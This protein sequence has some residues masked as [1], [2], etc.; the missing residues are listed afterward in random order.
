MR[1]VVVS[2]SAAN[3]LGGAELSLLTLL[4]YWTRQDPTVEPLVIG[5]M[6]SAA[7]TREV[8][9]RGWRSFD[10]PMTGWAVWEADGGRAQ[11]RL[12]EV[13]NAAAAKH[14]VEVLKVEQPDLVISNTLV[15][16]WGAI[17][18]AHVGVP[19]V[20]FVREFG[21]S[22]QGFLFPGGRE[23]ALSDIGAL[24]HTIV[25]NSRV[26]ADALRPH[27]P[28][29]DIAV[30]Y[31]PVD[32]E[33]VRT[34]ALE[35]AEQ[36]FGAGSALRVSVLGRVTGSKGQWRLIEA[37]GRLGPADIQVRFVG[38]ILD[39]G[40]DRQL[41]RRARALGVDGSVRF[42][43]EHAN[44]FPYVAQAEL[45]IIPSVKEAFGRSTLECLALGKPVITARAGAGAEL[46]VDGVCGALV[47]ADDFTGWAR[48]VRG[49]IDDRSRATRQGP[50]ARRRADEIDAGPHSLPVAIAAMMAAAAGSPARLPERWGTW[51]DQ[52]D[53][54]VSASTRGLVLRARLT[55]IS[56]LGGR[57]V[58]HPVRACRRLRA[59]LRHR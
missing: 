35:K 46:V 29:H 51:V 49:Y 15:M 23:A 11:L 32:L 22:S 17:A 8:H 18:A 30:V 27:M 56:T 37:L 33:R 52:L 42:L 54:L 36:V 28:D 58:R 40:A 3:H 14:I 25:A 1:V 2:H 16:P 19:H 6:P 20:W 44:P 26:V 10:L 39:I 13:R 47:D 43:G 55:R 12:R 4:D 5:P 7:M 21:E 59:L 34:G 50:D 41:L 57:A 48:A 53:A 24:S 38:G 9:A 31:P 45:C